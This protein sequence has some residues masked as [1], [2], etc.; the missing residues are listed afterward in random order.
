VHLLALD[1]LL[2]DDLAGPEIAGLAR[3]DGLLADVGKAVLEDPRR[4]LRA[5]AQGLLIGEI[6]RLGASSSFG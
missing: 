6:H 3:P 1:G 4:A 5:G 2:Q